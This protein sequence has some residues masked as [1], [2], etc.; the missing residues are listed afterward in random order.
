MMK[1]RTVVATLFFTL[2][3]A[4]AWAEPDYIGSMCLTTVS[5]ECV[6]EGWNVGQCAKARLRPGNVGGNGPS[7]RLSFFYDGFALN[8]TLPEGEI[9]GTTFRDVEGTRI[10]QSADQFPAQMR[11]R[12]QKPSTLGSETPVI[13]VS[14][15]IKV[16]DGPFINCSV[17]FDAVFQIRP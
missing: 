16:W 1:I 9:V 13:T 8:Y 6:D 17:G 5:T 12:S 4:T 15:G 14:G 3:S 11:F 2:G 10:G 7:T